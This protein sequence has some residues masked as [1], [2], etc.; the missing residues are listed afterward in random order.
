M[1]TYAIIPDKMLQIGDQFDRLSDTGA[2]G[3]GGNER[4][5]SGFRLGEPPGCCY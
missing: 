5:L 4:Y 3:P 1:N 2:P